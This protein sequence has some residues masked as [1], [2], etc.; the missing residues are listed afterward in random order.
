M[1]KKNRL[2]RYEQNFLIW[3]ASLS[4]RMPDTRSIA[5]G[6]AFNEFNVNLF[7]DNY[8]SILGRPNF[9]LEPHTHFQVG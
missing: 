2:N 7:F 8:G 3:T 9:K 1:L 6:S 4:L 5:R